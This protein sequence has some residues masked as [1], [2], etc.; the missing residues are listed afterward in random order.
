[1]TDL[2]RRETLRERTRRAVSNE[3]LDVAQELFAEKGYEQVTV[4][5][6]AE[7]AGISRRSFFRYFASKDAL[8]LGKFDRQGEQF[9]DALNARPLDEPL[10][11]ALRRMADEAVAYVSDPE[12]GKRAS[13]MER[14]IHTSES[15][16]AGFLQR[17]ENAQH[18]VTDAAR[19]REA[20]RRS[21]MSD[22]A[23]AATVAAAFSAL[24]VAGEHTRLHGVA[25]G[26]ALDEA[27]A[28]LTPN[29][30]SH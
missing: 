18:L 11:V 8:V 22:I 5:E 14:V 20:A 23:I 17:M 3:L 4:E 28:A 9:V 2:A 26:R 29:R 13:E 7:T 19:E 15:L 12:L 6:I 25:M 21:G 1:V 30:A 16:H 27:M 24:A 10:W